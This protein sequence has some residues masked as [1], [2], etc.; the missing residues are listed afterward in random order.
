MRAFQ[1]SVADAYVWIRCALHNTLPN[2]PQKSK[3][4]FRGRIIANH[5]APYYN[6]RSIHTTD[7]Q[8]FR[9]RT[10]GYCNACLRGAVLQKL[11][12]VETFCTILKL[13][14]NINFLNVICKQTYSFFF[15]CLQSRTC[16][17]CTQLWYCRSKFTDTF[18][19]S[20]IL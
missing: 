11:E 18:F 16:I 19:N 3:A 1:T 17:Q 10:N 9:N 12:F 14:D 7:E 6:D 5:A 4:R 20:L 2:G 13:T 8:L 15:F